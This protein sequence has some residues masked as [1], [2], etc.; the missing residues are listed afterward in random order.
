MI[1]ATD[2]RE[3]RAA[4]AAA[5]SSQEVY[6]AVDAVC[7]RRFQYILLT[8][9][10]ISHDAATVERVWSSNRVDYLV[11]ER[12][13]FEGTDEASVC[14]REGRPFL[15]ANRAAMKANFPDSYGTITRLGID[16]GA[17]VPVVALGRTL[18]KITLAG[19]GARLRATLMDEL[20]ELTPYLVMP[21]L[22]DADALASLPPATR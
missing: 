19:P 10:V 8:M 2:H 9:I 13:R 7:A 1:D 15:A 17:N 21:F 6:A 18:G 12:R 14:F 4:L 11:P 3:L 16:F 20:A 22:R 5:H